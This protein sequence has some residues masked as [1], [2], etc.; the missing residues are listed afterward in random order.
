MYRPFFRDTPRGQQVF[1]DV[2]RRQ[3]REWLALDDNSEGWPREHAHRLVL[4]QM[5]EGI[6]EPSV[7]TEIQQ[8]LKQMCA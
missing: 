3:P 4:T 6:S 8:K 7:K 2:L 5:Y 1:E